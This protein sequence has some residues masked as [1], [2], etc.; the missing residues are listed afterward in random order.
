MMRAG[1]IG[2]GFI[3]RVYFAAFAASLDAE[4]VAVADTDAHARE[5]APDVRFTTN[6]DELLNDPAIDCV[7]ILTPHYLHAS[8]A[9]AALE[10]G[11]H[12]IVEKP[13]AQTI[14]ETDEIARLARSTQRHLIVRQ[15]LRHAAFAIAARQAC[16]EAG[17]M[18][19]ASIRYITRPLFHDGWRG[20]WDKAWGGVLM[21][22]GFHYIDFLHDLLGDATV[23]TALC[24]HADGND[25]AEDYATLVMQ[26]DGGVLS[27]LS[28]AARD[29]TSTSPRFAWEFV[30]ERAR[31]TV[32]GDWSAVRVAVVGTQASEREWKDWWREANEAAVHDALRRV[33]TTAPDG[34]SVAAFRRN[35]AVV[36][37]AYAR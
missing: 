6:P 31:V 20:T 24:A 10:A 18:R 13:L 37:E 25:L 17:R 23:H 7:C 28:V 11:K 4:L 30:G 27:E 9:R 29:P 35:L 3:S 26:H 21:D 1:V 2:A 14:E 32:S 34:A 8:L 5:R 15:Y 12:V 36:R 19:W 16:A 33:A 22:I